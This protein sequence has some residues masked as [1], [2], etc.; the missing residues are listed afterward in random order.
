MPPGQPTKYNPEIH[1][2][3]AGLA[4][5]E[6]KTNKEIAA[7]LEISVGTLWNWEKEYP[8][9]LSAIKD[10][11]RLADD[12][13]VKSLFRR[14]CGYEIDEEKPLVVGT[15]EW[16]T[17]EIATVTKHIPPDPTSCIFWLKNRRPAE[18]RDKQ[19]I[20]HSGNISIIIDKDDEG[21]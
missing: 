2:A 11:K 3:L 5:S 20:E 16:A 19:D 4:A 9:F 8:E 14:A 6:G 13:V 10:G 17:L 15:G 18:W 7:A 1:P 21:L 12:E